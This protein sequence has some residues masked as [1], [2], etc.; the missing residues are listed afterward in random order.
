[1]S[2]R[3]GGGDITSYP[4]ARSDNG[5]TLCSMTAR[6]NLENKLG[7]DVPSGDAD[8]VFRNYAGGGGGDNMV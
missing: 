1:M 4:Y 5:T 7:L 8:S 2:G 6:L 3:V